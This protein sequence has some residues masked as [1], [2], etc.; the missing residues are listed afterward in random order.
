MGYGFA[1]M[2]PENVT[3]HCRKMSLPVAGNTTALSLSLSRAGWARGEIAPLLLLLLLF[4]FFSFFFFFFL[5]SL[6]SDWVRG[7]QPSFFF[8]F[9]SSPAL[10][11]LSI[12]LCVMRRGR[13][14]GSLFYSSE[15][16]RSPSH[17]WPEPLLLL[18]S[19]SLSLSL[20]SSHSLTHTSL[21]SLSRLDPSCTHTFYVKGVAAS[22]TTRNLVF[23]DDF[24]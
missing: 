23:G 5:L 13:E 8:F 22:R 21:F 9:S 6:G 3:T 10:F 18:G 17:T 4:S 20:S 11:L 1:A 19:S 24:I 16:E 15:G 7:K 14:K 2:L 12:S